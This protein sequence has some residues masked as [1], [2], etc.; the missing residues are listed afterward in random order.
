[1][2]C[3]NAANIGER[4]TWTQSEFCTWQN[5]VTGQEPPKMYKCTSSRDGQTPCKVWLASVERRRCSNEAKTRNPFAGVPQTRQQITAV[6]KPKSPYC[7][8]MWGKYCCL[9][10]FFRLSI[11]ALVAKIWPDKAMRWCA[12]GECLA[13]FCVL[14]FQQAAFSVF[15]TCILNLH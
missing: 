4:K 12:D 1:V 2:P 14:H 5:S 7:G 15:Q 6:S 8:N 9:T 13:I 10:T 3:S 11:C